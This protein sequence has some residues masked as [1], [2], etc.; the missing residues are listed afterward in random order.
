MYRLPRHAQL[1][2]A[3]ATLL[4]FIMRPEVALSQTSS[5]FVPVTDAMLQDPAPGDWLM[6]RRTLDSWGYSP[7]DQVNRDNVDE[8]S[9][10]WTRNLAT[11]TGEITPLAYNGVLYV[12]QG[13][14]VIQA[15]DALTGDLIWEYSRTLPEDLYEMVGGNARNNRNLAIFENLIINTSDDNFVFA[16]DAETGE[17]VWE[18]QIFD[19]RVN[20]ATHSSGP[21]IAD[22]RVISGRSCR[23]WGGPDA[24][25]IA[26]HDARTGAEL[27]RRRLIP[28]PGEP[29]DET[30]G[31]VPFEDRAHVGSWMVPSYD[32]ELKLL[33]LGTSV[34]SPAPKFFL[35]GVENEHLYH[36]STLALE[37]E[38]G[39]I[40]WHYQHLIDHWDLDHPFERLLVETRVSPNPDAV[41]WINPNLQSG[42]VRK[43]I[44]GIPGKT[45]VVYTLDRE[46]G[47]FLWATP[48][49]RQNVIESIDGNSGAV[50]VNPEVVFRESEQVVFVCPSWTGGKDWEAGAYSP[51]TN[52]MYYPLRN[53]CAN[54]L[55]TADFE[56]DTAQALTAG[57]Q[58]GLAIYSLAA[59][60]QIAPGT[61]NLG[62]VRAISAETGETAWLYEERASTMSLVATGGGL[63]FGGDSN[64]RFRAHDHET[65]EVLWEINLGSSVS[66]YPITY[67]VN[68]QQYVAVNTGAGQ[69][70]LTPELHPSRGTNLFVFALP[71]N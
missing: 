58:G 47:E 52:T 45:G 10:V 4:L 39:E 25:I 55:A 60:H 13:S 49:V 32:P 33:I 1:I 18:T 69:I 54:M 31:D 64:G 8:L 36:N 41:S 51:L 56:T 37:V 7:L 42:E 5:D 59:R 65:G 12:P 3:T 50:T 40:R 70:N 48:T 43:V 38:T 71:N 2:L 67:S 15:V 63:I 53:T 29:G 17:M 35:G 28:A 61:E 27:W 16:L 62:T 11:G 30:W 19:Y 22:G 44:T 68:G 34:T 21:I 9:M 6:W 57:G 66:G 20:S 23:P 46:T 24:C 26:A 14:D